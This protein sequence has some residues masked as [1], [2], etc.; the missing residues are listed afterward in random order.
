MAIILVDTF[1][2]EL[3]QIMTDILSTQQCKHLF[4]CAEMN[5]KTY[6]TPTESYLGCNALNT[7]ILVQLGQVAMPQCLHSNV[8]MHRYINMKTI[9][10][11]AE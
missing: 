6:V 9:V 5:M 4:L 11:H 7:I 8:F 1:L 3:L 10:T 2:Y